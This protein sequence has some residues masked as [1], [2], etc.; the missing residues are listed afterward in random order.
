MI[1]LAGHPATADLLT[2]AAK[3]DV[4]AQA[5]LVDHAYGMFAEGQVTFAHAVQVAEAWAR[6]AAVHRRS[7]DLLVLAGV[8]MHSA[9]VSHDAGDEDTHLDHVCESVFVLDDLVDQGFAP[10]LQGLTLAA[11]TLGEDTM[12]KVRA[13]FRSQK[14]QAE[15]GED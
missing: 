6:L 2:R 15:E 14:P 3:G 8:L 10:A 11:E 7:R 12:R 4:D 13:R 5:A 1:P 9:Q